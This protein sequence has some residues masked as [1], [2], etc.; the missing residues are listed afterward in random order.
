MAKQSFLKKEKAATEKFT[1][2]LYKAQQW[3][4]TH[5]PEEIADVVTPLFQDTSKDITVKV[6]ERYKKQHSYATDPLLDEKRMGTATSN[7][8]RSWR[9]T[10]RS[11]TS[12]ACEYK[13][14]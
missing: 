11:S 8:E 13:Y 3:V 9:I 5:T 1:R 14:C 10:K 6:I 7:H 4:D 12:S 2:A